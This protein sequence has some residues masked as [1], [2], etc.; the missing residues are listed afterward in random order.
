MT[1]KTYFKIIAY[2]K[3]GMHTSL[4]APLGDLQWHAKEHEAF[5]RRARFL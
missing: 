4:R 5:P 3:K 2:Y 1:A